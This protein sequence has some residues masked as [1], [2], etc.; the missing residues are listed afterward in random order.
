MNPNITHY[1]HQLGRQLVARQA[2]VTTA[3]SCTGGGIAEAITRISGSSAWFNCGFVTYSNRAKSQ[4]L[5]VSPELILE[6]GAVSEAV[7]LAMGAGALE[8]AEADFAVA[9]SGIAGPT[10][11]SEA[12]PVGTVWIAWVGPSGGRA[13]RFLFSGDRMLVRRQAVEHAL[14]GLIQETQ[15]TV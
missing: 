4:L 12:K 9:V 8:R 6:Q 11:G 2:T 1:A 10:G 3:E 15:Y 14:L 7:V 5:G 13:Q